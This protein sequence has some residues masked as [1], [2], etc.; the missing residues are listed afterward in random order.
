[1]VQGGGAAG[2]ATGSGNRG[3]GREA[4]RAPG[5]GMAGCSD[6]TEGRGEKVHVTLYM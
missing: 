2:L 6:G 4:K 3:A 5:V 1:M